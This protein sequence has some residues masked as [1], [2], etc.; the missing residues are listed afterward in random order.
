MGVRLQVFGV[1]LL[2][3]LVSGGAGL[4]MHRVELDNAGQALDRRVAAAQESVASTAQ[5]YVDAR[6][7][8]RR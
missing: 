8:D 3:L 1:V 2:G 7:T 6:A 4:L 5:R